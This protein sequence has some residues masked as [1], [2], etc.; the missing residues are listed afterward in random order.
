MSH[1][2]Q[3]SH[4]KGKGMNCHTVTNQGAWIREC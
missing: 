1:L 3:Q 4:E 2:E